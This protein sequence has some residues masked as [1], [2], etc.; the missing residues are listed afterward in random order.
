MPRETRRQR[1]FPPAS[2]SITHG[3][4][5][6]R[7]ELTSSILQ[8]YA[9]FFWSALQMPLKSSKSLGAGTGSSTADGEQCISRALPQHTPSSQKGVPSRLTLQ[10]RAAGLTELG[11]GLYAGG[12]GT[13]LSFSGATQPNCARP[14]Y[15]V[16][17][18]LLAESL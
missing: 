12:S 7:S 17:T 4:T 8:Q 18:F 6:S 13:S 2:V 5:H 9:R 1:W 14:S 16:R 15:K 10:Q 11:H 3:T